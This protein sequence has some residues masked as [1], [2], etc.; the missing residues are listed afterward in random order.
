[1]DPLV[2]ELFDDV[3]LMV[4]R[5][6]KH[7]A[8]FDGIFSAIGGSQ[9]WRIDEDRVGDGFRYTV[10][11]ECQ[12]LKELKP[13]A[14]D[15]CN[16][17]I[18]ALDQ[19]VGALTRANGHDNSQRLQFPWQLDEAKFE[20][21]LKKLEAYISKEVADCVRKTRQKCHLALPMAH[22]AK[23]ISNS[24]KHWEMVPS[25]ASVPAIAIQRPG[26]AQQIFNLPASTLE[27]QLYFTFYEGPDRLGQFPMLA[28]IGLRFAGLCDE[29]ATPTAV[30]NSA[31]HYV[32]TVVQTVA[33][34]EAVSV[35]AAEFYLG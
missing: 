2:E 15:L 7:K 32:E 24:G 28:L 20:R 27:Q 21:S 22:V 19:M 8:E 23:E 25:T 16:N 31:F 13:V 26:A 29:T 11:I 10:V 17:L 1:M 30:F 35:A 14:V 18:H 33:E 4:A 9:W 34:C 12:Q 6:R 5:A 3:R